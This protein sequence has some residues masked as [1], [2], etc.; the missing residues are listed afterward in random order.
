VF[1]RD[2]ETKQIISAVDKFPGTKDFPY[3]LDRGALQVDGHALEFNTEPVSSENEFVEVVSHVFGQVK[4]FVEATHPHL[5]I[6]LQP[7]ARFDASYFANLPEYS[8]ML[9]CNP[10]YSAQTGKELSAP[11]ITNVPIRTGSGHIHIGWTNDEDPFD[12]ANF[13]KRFI[14]ANRIT[15]YLLKAAK[16]WE[17]PESDARRIYYGREGAFRPKPYGVELRALDNLWLESPERML[18]VFRAA[19]NGFEQEYHYAS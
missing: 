3:P 5:E 4:Q 1:L 2:K 11:D 18:S 13:K 12:E 10:D 17:T 7:V 6:T 16:A 19:K 8:K 9:G 14:L 15:P